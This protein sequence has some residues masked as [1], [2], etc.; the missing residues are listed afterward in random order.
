MPT[1]L[2]HDD[3]LEATGAPLTRFP[4]WFSG[5]A[6]ARLE[7]HDVGR[8]A[9]EPKCAEDADVPAASTRVVYFRLHGSPV[10]Y[11]SSY[12]EAFLERLSRQLPAS[13]R[14]PAWCIFDNTARGAATLNAIDLRLKVRP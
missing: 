7:G 3:C 10:M 1:W 8:G 5:A 2:T 12:D 14:T 4:T 13:K 11:H 6:D 9:A